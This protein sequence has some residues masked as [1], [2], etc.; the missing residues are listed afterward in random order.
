MLFALMLTS[1]LCFANPPK[2]VP[3]KTWHVDVT[4]V[5]SNVIFFAPSQVA[6][7]GADVYYLVPCSVTEVL[8]N[9][10]HAATALVTKVAVATAQA[11][12]AILN[13]DAPDLAAIST[14]FFTKGPETMRKY[15][16]ELNFEKFGIRVY[17]RVSKPI[18]LPKLSAKG[19]PRPYRT[20]DDSSGNGFKY[21]D[22]ELKANQSKWDFVYSP[23][24]FRNTY[25]QDDS[26]KPEYQQALDQ[27][28]KEYMAAINDSAMGSGDYNA[29]GTTAAA[30]ATGFLTIIADEITATNITPIVTGSI[31]SSNAVTRVETMIS[32]MPAW[33]RQRTDVK[34]LCSYDVFDKYKAHYRTLNT[35]GFQPRETDKYFVD[36]TNVQLVPASWMGSSQRLIATVDG[37]LCAGTDGDA[38]SINPSPKFDQIEV[39]LKMPIGFQIADLEALLVND[40]A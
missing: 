34:I 23:E 36:G 22:R 9:A 12:G 17:K 40:Q 30:I 20:N 25:L 2:L 27:I 29:S 18:K 16:N 35:Y 24:E 39:R 14:G 28:A 15:V 33:M 1:A 11:T 6:V 37:N 7:K 32:N 26:D 13:A 31:S 3:D 21:S 8:Q 38:I 4:T 10:E 19:G 5:G